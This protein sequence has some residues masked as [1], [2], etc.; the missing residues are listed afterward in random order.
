LGEGMKCE[1][2]RKACEGQAYDG[3]L[4]DFVGVE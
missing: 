4:E 1:E 3:R 2:V